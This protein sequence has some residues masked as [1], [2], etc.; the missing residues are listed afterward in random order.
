[1]EPQNNVN[2]PTHYQ[3]DSGIECIDAIQAMSSPDEFV[4]FLK[5]NII[6]YVWRYK[7]KSGVEDLEKAQWYLNKLIETQQSYVKEEV[8]PKSVTKRKT[9]KSR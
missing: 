8:K 3:S 6:K 4:G 7:N 1:M 2:H 5:G 9:T